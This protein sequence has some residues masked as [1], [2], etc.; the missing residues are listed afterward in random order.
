MKYVV[1]LI[2]ELIL[3]SGCTQELERYIQDTNMTCLDFCQMQTHETGEGFTWNISGNVPN[4]ICSYYF[5]KTNVI[6]TPNDLIISDLTDFTLLN[7]DCDAISNIVNI[8][9]MNNGIGAIE[10]GT[11]TLILTDI[12][13]LE[14][15]TKIDPNFIGIS[16][17]AAKT[18]GFVLSYDL[19]VST[20][21]VARLTLSNGKTRTR[22]CTAQAN[23]NESIFQK[24]VYCN[25]TWQNYIN[26]EVIGL[27]TEYNVTNCNCFYE[28]IETINELETKCVCSCELYDLNGTLITNDFR[29]LLVRLL[30]L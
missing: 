17:G 27:M 8:T 26:N 19:K 14:L 30:I 18:F 21:Y 6:E 16:E 5:N 7:V 1:L 13:G 23:L 29:P 28:N 20:T 3:L 9:V 12:N 22:S 11:L 4:C 25:T 10:N 15:Y 24:N 2:F